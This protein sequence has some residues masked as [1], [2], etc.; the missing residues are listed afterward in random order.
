MPLPL[1]SQSISSGL[2]SDSHCPSSDSV[3]ELF[4]FLS[5]DSYTENAAGKI[6]ISLVELDCLMRQ[7][8]RPGTEEFC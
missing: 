7:T 8:L 2:Y 4:K 6:E 1:K 5:S 3:N